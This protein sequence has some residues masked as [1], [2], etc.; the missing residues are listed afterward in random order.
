MPQSRHTFQRMRRVS[1]VTE[2]FPPEVNGV[3]MTLHRLC[4]EWVRR[5][6]EVQVVCPEQH[7]RES[8]AAG[9]E[10][11]RVG[12]MPIPQ[13]PEARLGAW[14]AGRLKEAW[15][16]RRP[17]WVHVATEGLL[18]WSALRA[19]R[20]LDIPVVTSFH[21][22]FHDYTRHYGLAPL[23]PLMAAWLRV[24]H[25]AGGVCL[26][27][28]E[29]LRRD[30]EKMGIRRTG[31]LGRGVDTQLFHPGRRDESLRASWGAGPDDPVVVHVSRA[32]AEKNIPLVVEAW[33]QA[34]SF[35]P[36]LRLVLVGGGPLEGRLRR[37]C[38]EAIHSGMRHGEDLARHYASGDFFWFASETET[39]G[40][41]VME[42]M[43]CGLAVLAYDYA[44]A[45]QHIRHGI[46]GLKVS[47]GDESAFF[48]QA[49]EMA[50][51]GQ[52]HWTGLREAARATAIG[53]PWNR[54]VD[55]YF[56]EVA[57]LLNFHG[58]DA[59]ISARAA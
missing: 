27:P 1:L 21:T 10:E 34:R 24:F 32:A 13:Y 7:G 56:T 38:P 49:A 17:D 20:A 12:G 22:N 5:G 31:Y 50:R 52:A 16:A 28:D 25:N 54:V 48:R 40:N 55:H 3:A 6:L 23:R 33:R 30:L 51:S 58:A 18:G 39:Y 11:I 47:K 8:A 44:A 14:A 42:A 43:A 36:R 46:N 35:C 57:S 53:H 9:W 41:V 29:G 15:A 45:G 4:G 26:V 2:T 19:A 59:T 37:L